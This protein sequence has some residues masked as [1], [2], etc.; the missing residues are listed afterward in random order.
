MDNIGVNKVIVDDEGNRISFP[1]G[2]TQEIIEARVDELTGIMMEMVD[3]TGMSVDNR[4]VVYITGGGIASIKGI[5]E[6]IARMIKINTKIFT[7]PRPIVSSPMQAS[8][9]AGLEYVITTK[10]LVNKNN[11]EKFENNNY[12]FNLA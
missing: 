7:P 11:F 3:K 2:A 12:D 5:R 4:S 10:G 8:V 9:C 1:T 6:Y